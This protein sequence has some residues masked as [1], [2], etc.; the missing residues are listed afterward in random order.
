ML[1]AYIKVSDDLRDRPTLP[2]RL[3]NWLLRHRFQETFDYFSHLDP[4]FRLRVD[5]FV[6]EHLKLEQ[7]GRTIPVED[8]ARPTAAAFG[9]VFSLF[10]RL[11]EMEA[12][13]TFLQELGAQVGKAIIAFDCAMDWYKDQRRGAF[14]PLPDGE[15]SVE[16]S[17]AY[18]R[19]CLRDAALLCRSHFGEGSDAGRVLEAVAGRIPYACRVPACRRFQAKREGWLKRWGLGRKRGFQLNEG[20]DVWIG[21]AG[22]CGVCLGALACIF[23]SSRKN[24]AEEAARIARAKA[25]DVPPDGSPPTEQ[26]AA[27]QQQSGKKKSNDCCG[28]CGGCDFCFCVDLPDCSGMEGCCDACDGCSGCDFNC[29]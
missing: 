17:L 12:H 4:G 15:K 1:L 24:Q 5:G 11:S 7:P 9:Y 20:M 8:Y 29:G 25:A 18:A 22:F 6:D 13:T 14:N 16:A 23:T 2:I 3:M 26:A 28:D 27:A 21:I 19:R 10:G